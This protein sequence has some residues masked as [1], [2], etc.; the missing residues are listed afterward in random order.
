[1][2]IVEEAFLC[3]KMV[4]HIYM[5]ELYNFMEKHVFGII[6]LPFTGHDVQSIENNNI[7][8]LVYPGWYRK[9]CTVIMKIKKNK[10]VKL[11]PWRV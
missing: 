10:V 3:L 5:V 11:M 9:H 6:L 2:S 8:L 4:N 1:M 7:F